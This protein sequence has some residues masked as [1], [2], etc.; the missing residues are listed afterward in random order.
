[1]LPFRLVYHPGY[2]LDLGDHVFPSAKYGLIRERLLEEGAAGP[3][4]F[5]TPA[6]AGDED[7]ALAHDRLWIRRLQT[8]TLSYAEIARLEIPYSRRMV[9]AFWLAA[10]GTM[11][12]CR[13]A[14]RDRVAVNIGGGFHHAFRGHG[15]GFCAINDVAVGIRSLQRTGRI[16]RALVLDCDVHHGNGTAAI[17]A[18]DRKVFTISLH[19]LN[20]YPHEKPP[21]VIDVHLPDETGDEEYLSHLRTHYVAALTLHRPNL[22][23]YLAGADPYYQDQLG[24]LSLTMGGLRQRDR[25]AVEMALRAGVPVAITLAG[26]YAFR[27]EDTVRIHC[28]TVK[29]AAD[30]ALATA[31]AGPP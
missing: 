24:G 9:R 17:F 28:N 30:A 13:L 18:G 7:L 19:Q 21:S 14:L 2:D 1:M 3:E 10:G 4:D 23:V 20:N 26:G 25:F 22:V 6:P 15:E 5:V 11:L 31:A 12:A 8:G 29:A 27:L 16:D